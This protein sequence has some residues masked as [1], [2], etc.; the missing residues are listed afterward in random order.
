MKGIRR[1]LNVI[2]DTVRHPKASFNALSA[3]GKLVV[4][5]G[6]LL[7]ATGLFSIAFVLQSQEE[8]REV[9]VSNNFETQVSTLTELQATITTVEG[10]V[11]YKPANG[12]WQ[13]ATTETNLSSQDEVRTEG[14]AS[15]TIISYEDGSE[16][17]LDGDTYIKIQATTAE[18]IET[19]VTNGKTYNRVVTEATPYSVETADANYEAL[20][21][22]F[23]VESSGDKQ[24]VEVVESS[25]IE[26]T[27]NKT[28]DSGNRLIMKSSID[29]TDNGKVERIDINDYKN[30]P[31][32]E[33]NL[34]KD[35]SNELFKDKLGFLQDTEAPTIEISS[36]KQDEVILTESTSKT[37]AVVIKGKASSA[38]EVTITAKSVNGSPTFEATVQSNGEFSSPSINSPLGLNAYEIKAKD[39]IGNISTTSLRITV[40]QKSAPVEEEKTSLLILKSVSIKNDLLTYTWYMSEDINYENVRVLYSK[41]DNPTLSTSEGVKTPNK[42]GPSPATVT[43]NFDSG[44]L[45]KET[46]YIRMCELNENQTACDVVSDTKSIKIK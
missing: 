1:I 44:G 45:D 28:I 19:Y 17:R 43:A 35:E 39:R 23:V 20:G 42:G 16:T 7:L 14:A 5:L 22:A 11:E 33:W 15:R 2:G 9:A 29:P 30:D 10:N 37:G 38:V 32:I 18:K 12:D 6:A 27:T 25:I 41:T 24:A 34:K 8:P 4:F 46:Y 40:Q 26:T 13:D 3:N 21:T 31:F 36:P